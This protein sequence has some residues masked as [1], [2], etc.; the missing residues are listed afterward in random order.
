MLVFLLVAP[1]EWDDGQPTTD[2]R[3]HIAAHQMA[4]CPGLFP[5]VNSARFL[6]LCHLSGLVDATSSITSTLGLIVCY[7]AEG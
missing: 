5:K 2:D 1:N 4:G 7:N 6:S 3:R